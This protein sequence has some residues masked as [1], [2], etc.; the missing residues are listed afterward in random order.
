AAMFIVAIIGAA[1]ALFAA[2]I[3]LAQWDIKKV[4]AYS[5]ISQLGYMFLACGVGAFA[6]GI[7]HVFTHAFFKALLFLGSGSGVV[8]L[9]HEQDMRRRGGLKRF[10]PI[11]FA[12][13]LVGW[14][15]IS[16]VPLLS[17]FFSKDEILYRS[18]VA[19]G[20][21]DSWAR[22]L[23]LVGAVTALLTAIYMTRLM[24]LTFWGNERFSASESAPGANSTSEGHEH[25]PSMPHESPRSMTAPLVV[26]AVGAIFVGYV[27]IPAALSDA[28]VPN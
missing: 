25:H 18:F 21:P 4:L 13:M 2:T 15:A 26:L 12:T 9:H 7:F 11:T 20:L 22:V 1:T 19:E 8:G 10:M 14:L 3:G 17:G 16:G 5:T 28:R 6:A 23:W 24:V 27:G